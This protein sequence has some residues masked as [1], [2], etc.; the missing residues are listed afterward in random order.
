M[1]FLKCFVSCNFLQG[2]SSIPA[3]AATDDFKCPFATSV[4]D[5]N[6]LQESEALSMESKTAAEATSAHSTISK[7]KYGILRRSNESPEEDANEPGEA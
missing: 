6:T 5:A 3:P 4:G 1:Q 7:G 2:S